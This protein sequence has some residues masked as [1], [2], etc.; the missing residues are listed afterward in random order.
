LK[1]A[2]KSAEILE[3]GGSPPLFIRDQTARVELNLSDLTDF[4]R[5]RDKEPVDAFDKSISA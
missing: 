3:C 2:D 5:Q 1:P 4:L